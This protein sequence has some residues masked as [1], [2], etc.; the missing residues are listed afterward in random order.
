[1]VNEISSELI[2]GT[3]V[4]TI[5]MLWGQCESAG[6]TNEALKKF[7]EQLKTLSVFVGNTTAIHSG[8]ALQNHIMK[9]SMM[10]K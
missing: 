8:V 1:M 4:K 5:G 10:I 9:V 7:H 2:E 6:R 3:L